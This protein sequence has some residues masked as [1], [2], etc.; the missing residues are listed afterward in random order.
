[1]KLEIYISQR[2]HDGIHTRYDPIQVGMLNKILHGIKKKNKKKELL[3]TYYYR[4]RGK[5]SAI[6]T[7]RVIFFI[8]PT[9]ERV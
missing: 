4:L 7:I 5:F 9:T 6:W 3:P 2:I 8:L 1:M